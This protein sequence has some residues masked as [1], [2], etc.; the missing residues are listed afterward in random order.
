[1]ITIGLAECA[2]AAY[3]S[4]LTL[5]E[6]ERQY[7]RLRAFYLGGAVARTVASQAGRIAI[8]ME[9]AYWQEVSPHG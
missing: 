4:Y 2:T 8:R 7:V 5:P 1:L 9:H 3:V 6:H